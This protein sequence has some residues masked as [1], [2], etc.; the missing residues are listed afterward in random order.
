MIACLSLSVG[1]SEE[2]EQEMCD[3]TFVAV[4]HV[5]GSMI[6]YYAA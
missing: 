4:K 3:S 2:R 5:H 6:V 1:K